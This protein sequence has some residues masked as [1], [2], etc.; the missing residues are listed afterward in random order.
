MEAIVA[1]YLSELSPDTRRRLAA[2]F[3][4]EVT[5]FAFLVGRMTE[6]LQ[7][8]HAQSPNQI[9]TPKFAAFTLMTRGANALVA[10]FEL[11]LGGYM[12]EPGALLRNALES[13]A[14]AWD[15]VHNRERFEAWK[16]QKNFKSTDSITN[17][18]RVLE[19]YGKMYGHLS[20]LYVHTNPISSS[21]SML[22]VEGRPQLQLF[23]SIPAGK[24]RIRKSEIYFA[25]FASYV[26]LQLTELV[27][28]AHSKTLETIEKIPGT[29]SARNV[30]SERHRPFAEAMKEHFGLM[31]QNPEATLS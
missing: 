6:T 18:K 8:F 29:D 25:L 21:P 16:Q 1:T 19:S 17:V 20:K 3:S 24:E 2:H 7:N 4:K 26:C 22:V 28:H 14:V 15:V 30:V 13:F 23:G 9:S 27:F 12:W 31:S 11:S 5:E 10:A